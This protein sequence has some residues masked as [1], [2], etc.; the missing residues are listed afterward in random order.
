MDEA[1]RLW[2]ELIEASPHGCRVHLTGGEAFGQWD[3]LIELC[4]RAKAERL[5]PLANVETNAF[6][7]TDERIVRDRLAALDAA[8]MDK[9]VISADPYHQQYVPI[10][11]PR[12]AARVAEDVLTPA[13]VQVRWRDW[14][15]DGADTSSMAEADRRELFSRYAADGRDRMN[16]R[17]TGQLAPAIADKSLA[18]LAGQ[19]CRE[20]ILRNRQVH[21]GPG[22]WIMPGVCAGIVIGRAGPRRSVGD[23]WRRLADDHASRPVLGALASGGPVGLLPLA[24]EAGFTPADRYAGKC[25]LCWS[26][27]LH[28][29]SRGLFPQELGPA[30]LYRSAMPVG[31]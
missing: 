1:L 26:I 25:H 6:W 16:G 18:D 31:L 10:D 21:V 8:G 24:T 15:A 3:R 11:R 20:A 29:H 19:P 28:L 7:A 14:L 30:E 12:L 22:G 4:R 9:F 5:G 17:A 27:R 2:R 13:R 23:C